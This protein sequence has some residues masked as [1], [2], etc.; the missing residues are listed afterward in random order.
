MLAK[1][2]SRTRYSF[3]SDNVRHTRA[4]TVPDERENVFE[5]VDCREV[6]PERRAA[7]QGE[8]PLIARVRGW[9][10]LWYNWRQILS[11]LSAAGYR[12]VGPDMRG[13]SQTDAPPDPRRALRTDR[14]GGCR[15]RLYGGAIEALH[16]ARCAL[17][18]GEIGSGESG[19]KVGEGGPGRG[20][21]RVAEEHFVAIAG[22]G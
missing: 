21:Q 13:Y 12:A 8:G 3:S 2:K 19:R 9:P 11:A 22:Q 17:W 15:L 18:D 20:R 1:P 6:F 4:K 7:G 10:E 16:R 5:G 14:E